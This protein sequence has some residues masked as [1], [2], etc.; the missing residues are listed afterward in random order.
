MKKNVKSIGLS[1]AF[2]FMIGA[3][4]FAH[5]TANPPTADELDDHHYNRATG[6]LSATDLTLIR[7][8]L[9]IVDGE[10][11]IVGLQAILDSVAPGGPNPDLRAK[12]AALQALAS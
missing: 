8:M 11:T 4:L 10:D 12:L 3:P 1:I 6:G 5:G 9:G 2:I 7:Q